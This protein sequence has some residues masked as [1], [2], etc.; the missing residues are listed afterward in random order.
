MSKKKWRD[1][2]EQLSLFAEVEP[3]WIHVDIDAEL[4]NTGRFKLNHVTQNPEEFSDGTIDTDNS[5][6]DLA[7]FAHWLKLQKNG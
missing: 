6:D 2:T 1:N 5:T 4:R 7:K 3:D